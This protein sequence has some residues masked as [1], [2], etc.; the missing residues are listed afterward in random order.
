MECRFSLEFPSGLI[1]PQESLEQ[2]A[3]REL[4]EET[5]Y[6]GNIKVY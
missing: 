5:G 3:E 1:D 2:A 4:A 6:H